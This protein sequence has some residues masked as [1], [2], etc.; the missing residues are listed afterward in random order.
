MVIA[1]ERL[2]EQILQDPRLVEAELNRSGRWIPCAL[3]DLLILELDSTD[4]R[5]TAD[6]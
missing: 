2:L 3:M 6:T 5:R 4:Q 1:M